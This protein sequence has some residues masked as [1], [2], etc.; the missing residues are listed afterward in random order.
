MNYCL[1]HSTIQFDVQ[2]E[3]LHQW[4]KIKTIIV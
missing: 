3:D 2:H 1:H 4:H